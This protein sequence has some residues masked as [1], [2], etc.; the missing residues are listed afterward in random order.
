MRASSRRAPARAGIRARVALLALLAPGLGVH[1]PA[2]ERTAATPPAAWVREGADALR[3]LPGLPA[4]LTDADFRTVDPARAALGHLLFHDPLLS[5]NRNVACASCHH[6]T[7]GGA[8]GLSLGLGEGATGLGPARRVAEGDAV[9]HR[10][11]RHAPAL[12]NLG[13]RE[14][15]TLFHDGRVAIDPDEPSG[16]D[17]PAEEFLPRGLRSV[18]AAQALFPLLA[19]VEMAGGVD[20]N[21]VAGARR[22]RADYGWREIEARLRATPGYEAP[23]LAAHPD[24]GSLAEL[25]IV[26]VGNALDDFMAAEWRADDS[27]FDRWLAGDDGALDARERAGLALFYGEAGCARCHAGPLQTDHGFHALGLPAFGPG[28]TR[29]FDPVARDVGRL[30][31]SDDPADAY[32]FRTPSLRNVARTAPYGH[33]GTHATLEAV[34]RHHL[35]PLGELRRWSPDALVLPADPDGALAVEDFLG[36]ED[37]REAARRARHLDIEPRPALARDARA[38][39][40]LVAFLG[41]LTDRSAELGRFGVPEAVPS[42]LPVER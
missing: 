36:A 4:P 27:P 17:S 20:E 21:E 29:A 34:V 37:P 26:D 22:R 40:A 8:D 5:G 38:V 42:G 10:V 7:L 6:P 31:E 24:R 39:G 35:D 15:T 23:F 30:A 9:K 3:A 18:V 14:F 41:A 25:T 19:E 2:A 28:R 16:Y 11:P 32:R 1:A 12:F 13:A 33:A